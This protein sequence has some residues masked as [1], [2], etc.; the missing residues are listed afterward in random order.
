MTH[1][2]IAVAAWVALAFIAIVTLSPLALRPEIGDP[3]LERFG[4]YALLGLLFVLAYPRHFILAAILIVGAAIVLEVLQ[5]FTP[6][7][8]GEFAN[9]VVKAAGGLLGALVAFI[10]LRLTRT[11]PDRS[12]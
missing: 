1:R 12:R 11:D 9:A 5:L 3:N 10:V 4:A 2:L 6:D 8:D 7:R